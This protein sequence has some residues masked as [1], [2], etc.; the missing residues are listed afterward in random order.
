[1][2]S[3]DKGATMCKEGSSIYNDGTNDCCYDCGTNCCECKNSNKEDRK[4]HCTM[5]KSG[6]A[7]IKSMTYDTNCPDNK[8]TC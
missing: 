3:A 6:F 7:L 1:M 4:N 2:C 8:S 5:C